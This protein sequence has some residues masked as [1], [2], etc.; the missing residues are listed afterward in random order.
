MSKRNFSNCGQGLF[1][2]WPTRAADGVVIIK[3]G[4]GFS[5]FRFKI[6]DAF[7]KQEQ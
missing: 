2:A 4:F 1:Q 6:F 3:K 7:S 5:S